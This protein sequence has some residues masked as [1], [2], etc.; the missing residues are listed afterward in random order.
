MGALT[1]F[2]HSSTSLRK[3]HGYH[4]VE[5]PESITRTY[6][7][8]YEGPSEIPLN[9]FVIDGESVEPD[10]MVLPARGGPTF[11]SYFCY[12]GLGVQNQQTECRHESVSGGLKL[13]VRIVLGIFH[14]Q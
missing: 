4:R 13:I 3:L 8:V 10:E 11:H 7:K 5:L 2:S 14:Q 1:T 12:I 9:E 6:A